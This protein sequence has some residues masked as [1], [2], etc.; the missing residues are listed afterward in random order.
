MLVESSYP[1]SLD[2]SLTG[3]VQSLLHLQFDRQAVGIPPPLTGHVISLHRPVPAHDIFVQT[4]QHMMNAGAAVDGGRSLIEGEVRTTPSCLNAL[5]EDAL[6]L[7]E[8]KDAIFELGEVDL[9][10]YLPEHG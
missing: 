4:R 9:G 6:L 5:V 3:Y 10:V 2:L 7:P 8:A 1:V